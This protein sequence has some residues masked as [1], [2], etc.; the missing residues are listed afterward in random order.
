MDR[1]TRYLADLEAQRAGEEAH[2]RAGEY[3]ERIVEE[4]AEA[5]LPEL[6]VAA[7]GRAVTTR[8]AGLEVS[9][10][11][12]QVGEDWVLLEVGA[13]ARALVRISCTEGWEGLPV[14]RGQV[15][16]WSRRPVT[17]ALRGLRAEGTPI[18]LVTTTGTVHADVRI[19]AV[20]ADHVVVART[21]ERRRVVPTRALALVRTGAED[22]AGTWS[23]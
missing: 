8:V 13:G 12:D 20:G 6:L 18:A 22:R 17:A 10:V 23:V 16:R 14:R 5:T 1:F 11:I 2:E 9:G 7:R 4:Y 15:D 19:A 21:R 3:G